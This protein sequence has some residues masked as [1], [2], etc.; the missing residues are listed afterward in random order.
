LASIVGQ[1]DFVNFIAALIPPL[2]RRDKRFFF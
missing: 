1:P 2:A